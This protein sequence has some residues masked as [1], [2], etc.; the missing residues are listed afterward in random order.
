MPSSN[1]D[2]LKHDPFGVGIP[3]SLGYSSHPSQSV[4]IR[5]SLMN[6][7]GLRNTPASASPALANYEKEFNRQLNG[8]IDILLVVGNT[9][10]SSLCHL[11]NMM[12]YNRF[13]SCSAPAVG[14][15]SSPLVPKR[16]VDQLGTSETLGNS[17]LGKSPLSLSENSI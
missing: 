8:L 6:V 3:S 7:A 5:T 1:S 14:Y 15:V 12:D 4:E 10:S 9:E 13:Y 16:F 17:N 11:C 2:P